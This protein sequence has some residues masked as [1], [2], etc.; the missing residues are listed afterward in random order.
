VPETA[1]REAALAPVTKVL[2]SRKL[3]M[4]DS[5]GF[6]MNAFM[7]A[8]WFFFPLILTQRYHLPLARFWIVLVPMVLASGVTM[9]LF[10][11]GADLGWGRG[12]T[13]I[14][15]LMMLISALLLFRPSDA[16]LS[17]H[18]WPAAL[19]SGTLF[20]VGF[21]GLEPILPSLVTRVTHETSY[22]TAM[23]SFQTLQYLGS[24]AG[25]ALAGALA[26]F[27]SIWPM[28]FLMVVSI[29]GVGLMLLIPLF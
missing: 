7:T 16:G 27:P 10:S 9:F 18:H 5:G 25:G 23:G 26:H 8:F 14:A 11:K 21:T 13:T 28:A 1:P 24:F 20:L 2:K 19:I 4:I 17:P 6:M 22:G 12:L 29:A 3:I 15:F